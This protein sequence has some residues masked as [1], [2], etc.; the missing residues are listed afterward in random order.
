MMTLRRTLPFA[1]LA[2]SLGAVWALGCNDQKQVEPPPQ[3]P[4]DAGVD[5]APTVTA[6]P[7]PAPTVAACDPVQMGALSTMFEGRKAGEAPGMQAEG[8]P[9]CNVVPEGQSA[10]SQIFTLQQ[11]YCY[12]ILG[13]SLPPVGE[14]DMQLELDPGS[15]TALPPPFN[16]K[17]VLLTDTEAGNS[18]SMGA[19]QNCYQWPIPFPAA[20]RVTL[21]SRTGSGPVAAQVYKKKK[22]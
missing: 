9:L 18:G 7:P 1:L 13:A 20:V 19:K 15:G 21:K 6:P 14:L 5:A 12:T 16:L 2:T 4:P 8:A 3:P 22:L 17:P 11:G 10:S